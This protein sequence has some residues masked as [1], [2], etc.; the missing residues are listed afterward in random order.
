MAALAVIAA[1][2]PVRANPVTAKQAAE[3]V[4]GWL[5]YDAK[6]MG[7]TLSGQIGEVKGYKGPAGKLAYYVVSLAPEGFVIVP[8]D[9]L[10]E[11]IIAFSPRGK[12]EATRESPW[13]AIVS[14]D[15]PKRVAYVQTRQFMAA[16]ADRAKARG[17]LELASKRWSRLR[18]AA[19]ELHT[20]KAVPKAPPTSVSDVRVAPFVATRWSQGNS[21]GGHCYNYYTPN[22]YVCGCVATALAQVL[23]YFEVPQFGVGTAQFG[24]SVDMVGQTRNLRGGDGYGGPYD[25]GNMVNQ[26][27]GGLTDAQRRAIGALCHDAGVSVNMM[28]AAGGSG[29]G[30]SRTMWALKNVFGYSGGGSIWTGGVDEQPDIYQPIMNCNFDAGRPVIVSIA[31]TIEPGTVGHA[32]VG[33]GYGYQGVTQYH[34][35]NMGWGGGSDG[36]Y[37]MF[38]TWS[39]GG[40]A[41]DTFSGVGYNIYVTG[42]DEIVSGRVV[43]GIH[44]LYQPIHNID[45]TYTI[46]G[47]ATPAVIGQARTV[48]TNE[49]GIFYFEHVPSSSTL[50]VKV[51]KP[52]YVFDG[53]RW[54]WRPEKFTVNPLVAA[55]GQSGG[56]GSGNVWGLAYTGTL[57]YV[58][59]VPNPVVV[60]EG[61]T[62]TL[63]VRLSTEPNV[64]VTIDVQHT[65]GDADLH[66]T[67]GGSLS[68]DRTNWDSFQLVTI[69]A[70]EDG[71]TD[72]GY[73][74]IRCIGDAWQTMTV[75]AVEQ[76][77]DL[78]RILTD[79][80][81]LA[82]TEGESATFQVK[83]S[84]APPQAIVVNA[85]RA[86]SARINI[87][88]STAIAFTP[89]NWN[90]YQ[91]VTLTSTLDSGEMVN[92]QATINLTS[93]IWQS[94]SVAVTEHD[95]D[96]LEIVTDADNVTVPENS[97]AVFRVWLRN[98][99]AGPVNVAVAP[100]PSGD[101]DIRVLS[102]AVLVF[103]DTNWNV[104]QTVTLFADPDD[105]D[106]INGTGTITCA[107]SGGYP[108][109]HVFVTEA[110][111][112]QVFVT[113]LDTVDVPENG[114]A[115]L[116]A[117]LKGLPSGDVMVSVSRTIGDGD[118]SV[119]SGSNM[120]FT[121]LNWNI[122]QLVTLSAADDV[123]VANGEATILIQTV[124]SGWDKKHVL[125]R[126]VDDDKL[127]VTDMSVVTVGEGLTGSFQVR[128]GG[129]PASNVFVTVRRD[130]GDNDIRVTSSSVLTFGTGNWNTYQ[131]VDLRAEEDN[132]V[133]EG[134]A[135]LTC[136]AAGWQ[137]ATVLA[138]E[139]ENDASLTIAVTP[140]AGARTTTPTPGTHVYENGMVVSATAA[141]A[142][143][144]R[145][146]YWGGT[147]PEGWTRSF[148]GNGHDRATWLTRDSVGNIYVTG[149]F[150][151]TVDFD[152]SFVGTDVRSSNGNSDIFVT[153]LFSSGLYAWTRT[154]G[155]SSNDYPR[156]VAIDS[157]SD[158]IVTGEFS[159]TVDFDPG[160]GVENHSSAGG[161][162]AFV[163][164]LS[165]G[166]GSHVWT[167]TIGSTLT[168]AGMGVAV[169]ATD[170]LF[171]CGHFTGTVDL[172]PTSGTDS[173]VSYGGTDV[174][175][176]KLKSDGSYRWGGAMG[177]VLDDV[178]GKVAV[179]SSGD[180]LVVGSFQ[181]T[182]DFDPQS[183]LASDSSH[184]DYDIFVTKVH[185]DGT[186]GWVRTVGSSSED[187]GTAVAVDGAGAVFTTGYYSGTVDFDPTSGTD[188]RASQGNTD[189]FVAKLGT[190]GSYQW[191]R[192]IGG[193][194][195]DRGLSVAVDST[196]S[197]LVTGYFGGTA[198]FIDQAALPS[199][200]LH[201]SVG[202]RDVF[203]TRFQGSGG[204]R[205]SRTIGGTV[206]DEG[207]AVTTDADRNVLTVGR[208]EDTVDFDPTPDFYYRSSN[209][210]SDVFVTRL[211]PDGDYMS[212]TATS[213]ANPVTVMVDRAKTL[214][215][216]FE[217][218][219]KVIL[220]DVEAVTVAEGGSAS[221]LVKLR[222]VPM[223]SLTVTVVS[224]GDPDI[225]VSPASQNLVFNESNWLKYQ[226]V[227]LLAG[228]DDDVLN[229]VATITCSAAGWTTVAVV[230]TEDDDDWLLR[231][232]VDDAL[233]GTTVPA[234]GDHGY[235]D[236]QVISV[237]A[238]AASGYR[239][240]HWTGDIPEGWCRTFGGTG[241]DAAT[242]VA[243]SSSGE[244]YVC[245]Y[246]NG[247]V[248]FDPSLYGSDVRISQGGADIFVGKFD[249]NG[250][251]LWA[252][253]MGGP[254]D[255]VPWC[256]AVDAVGDVILTGEFRGTVDLDPTA[257]IDSRTSNGNG[258]VFVTKLTS[259]GGYV[260]TRTFGSA[261][262]DVGRGVAV[263]S[264][265]RIYVT[266]EFANTVAFD[267]T[268]SKMSQGG[269]DVFLTKL[270]S[271][272]T[273]VWTA[274]MGGTEDDV[275][276]GVA[277]DGAD[278]AYVVGQFRDWVDFDPTAADDV[279]P[280]NG[281]EDVFVTKL[282]GDGSYGWTRVAGGGG[283]DAATHVLID[284]NLSVVVCGGFNDVV[285]FDPA[286]GVDL[287]T[288][289]GNA[290][291]FVMKLT[292]GGLYQWAK[293]FGGDAGDMA[294]A[295]ALDVN[296][297]VHVAGYFGSSVDFDPSGATATFT[298]NGSSDAFYT[299][300]SSTG[301]YSLTRTV[302]SPSDDDATGI[303]VMD[304]GGVCLVGS[305][306][307]EVN[308]DPISGPYLRESIGDIDVF[309][310]RLNEDG[311]Y[312]SP[313]HT[314]T[315]NPLW[316]LMDRDKTVTAYFTTGTRLVVADRD[317]V[318]V[319]EGSSVLFQVKLA[320]RPDGP[321][322]VTVT[323]SGD[324]DITVEPSAATLTFTSSN[325]F[326][327]QPVTLHAAE[328]GDP[329]DGVATVTCAA[330][331]WRPATVL[332]T[333]ADDDVSLTVGVNTLT[334]G[335]TTPAPGIYG[336]EYGS[337]VSVT[338]AANL[339]YWFSHWSGDTPEGWCRSWGSTGSDEALGV[340]H[341]GQGNVYIC[342]Y[343]QGVVDLDPTAG[344][345]VHTSAGGT[346]AF[347]IKLTWDG[348]FS[349]ARSL[350]GPDDDVA[351]AVAV[352]SAGQVYITGQFRDTVDFDSE[353]GPDE[354]TS[355]GGADVFITAFSPAGGYVRAFTFGGTDDE[356]ARGVAV[357]SADAVYAAGS[358]RTSVDFDPSGSGDSRTS[359]GES[360]VF[361]TKHAADGSYGWTYSL[362]STDSDLATAVAISSAGGVYFAGR[363]QGTI[364]F[365][366]GP[367]GTDEHSATGGYDIF[368]TKLDSAAVYQWTRSIGDT[369]QDYVEGL[370]VDTSGNVLLAGYFF[371]TVDFD[372]TTG[373]DEHT[374]NGNSD[375]FVTKLSASGG[376]GWTRTFGGV[377]ND[378]SLGVTADSNENV[379]LV[380]YFGSIVDFDPSGPVDAHTA[381][382]GRDV[383]VTQFS[384]T[385]VYGWTRVAGGGLPDEA[386]SVNA[387]LGDT[388]CFAGSFEGTVNFDPI[389]RGYFKT[390]QGGA[391]GFVTRL[392]PNGWYAFSGTTSASAMNLVMDRAT[393]VQAN[394][395]KGT[396]LRIYSDGGGQVGVDGV[397]YGFP[398]AATFVRGVTTTVQALPLVGRTV[399]GGWSDAITGT[400]NPEVVTM[401]V[402]RTV[403][404]HFNTVLTT[405]VTPVAGG[406]IT[407]T[408]PGPVYPYGTQVTL[409]AGP[410]PFWA[411]HDWS[412]SISTTTNPV[413]I[414]MDEHKAV[415][416]TFYVLLNTNVFPS[417]SG[418]ITAQPEGPAYPLGSVV[419]LTAVENAG[420]TFASWSGDVS[421]YSTVVTLTMDSPKTV[422]AVFDALLT[423][424]VFPDGSG[425]ITADPVGPSYAYNTVVTLTA[426]ESTGW[427]FASW[428][429]H[430]SGT[431]PVVTI[432]MNAPKAVT[433]TFDAILTTYVYPPQGGTLTVQ[434]AGP[435]YPYNTVVTLTALPNTGWA[436]AS[437]SG[438]VSAASAVVTLTMDGPKAATATFD[439]I[440][441]IVVDPTQGGTIT[442]SPIGP[443]YAYNSVVT[444]TATSNAGWF[445]HVWSGA[446]TG[447]A[448]LTS[449]TMDAPKTVT[450]TFRPLLRRGVFPAGSGTI[451]TSPAGPAYEYGSVI[452][453]TAVPNSGWAFDFWS[454]DL[455]GT[456]AVTT[457]TMDG[458]K[459]VTATFRPILTRHVFPPGSG[460]ITADPVGPSYTYNSVVTVTAVPYDGWVF[461]SWSG[462][463]S[464]AGTVVT[465]TVDGPKAV[466][467]TF[468]A[469]LTLDVFPEGTGTI[470]ASPNLPAYPYNT[471]VTLT[472]VPVAGW[473]FDYWAGDA[474][475]T[476]SVVTVTMTSPKTVTA[477]FGPV[478][479]TD[480]F[481]AGSG[482]IS[483][484]PAGPAY[485]YME[486]VT[487]T[488]LPN[489]GWSF[490][491][492]SGAVTATSAVVTLTMDSPKTVTAYFDPY[493]SL[494]VDPHG[495]G[496][497]TA[498]P[499]GPV[500]PYDSVV[501][502]TSVANPG[503]SFHQWSGAAT[504]PFSTVQVH[505]DG[506]KVVTA[507]FWPLLAT[508]IDP[509]D[510]GWV[511]AI[512]TGP[513]YPMG[514]L[515]T[516]TANPNTGWTFASWSGDAVGTTP[517]A[518]VL[519]DAPKAVTATFG[520]LLTTHVSPTGS[521]SIDASPP[522]PSYPFG[523][524]VTLSATANPNWIF[525]S[526]SGDAAGT[527]TPVAVTME[528]PK[529]VT[530]NFVPLYM[531]SLTSP[532]GFGRIMVNGV[533]R[534]F[535][536]GEAFASGTVVQVEAVPDTG[537]GLT[538]WGGDLSG[539]ESPTTITMNGHKQVQAYFTELFFLHLA[540]EGTGEG[541]VQVYET[542][543]NLP[544][545]A[546]FPRTRVVTLTAVPADGS[547]FN[548]W[549]GD[550][551]SKA[552]PVTV[553]V[554]SE[555]WVAVNFRLNVPMVFMTDP[556]GLE[557]TI[558]GDVL[559]TPV[560]LN[561]VPGSV[562][563]VTAASP[564]LAGQRRHRFQNWSDGEGQT[565]QITAEPKPQK[566][567]AVFATEFQV[568]TEVNPAG[569]G[570]VRVTPVTDGWYEMGTKVRFTAL[571][572]TGNRFSYWDLNGKL[573]K[574][575]EQVLVMGKAPVHA[576]ANMHVEKPDYLVAG[577]L[578]P[579][580]ADINQSVQILYAISNQG[581][582]SGFQVFT[583][584]FASTDKVFSEDDVYLGN[585]SMTDPPPYSSKKAAA[586]LAAPSGVL[587][588]GTYLIFAKADYMPGGT[589]F[590]DESDETNNE[591][592]APFGTTFVV[593]SSNLTARVTRAPAF[594]VSGG[595]MPVGYAVG[596]DG[597]EP[598]AR[599]Y[600]R[601]VLSVNQ[602]IGDADDISLGTY[603]DGA[604]A[605]GCGV[606]CDRV[607]RVPSSTP[608]GAYYVGVS[609]DWYDYVHEVNGQ[610]APAEDDNVGLSADVVQIGLPVVDPLSVSVCCAS[611]VVCGHPLSV[612]GVIGNR[613]TGSVGMYVDYRLRPLGDGMEVW[614]G[615]RYVGPVAAGGQVESPAL[616][617]VPWKAACGAYEL[618]QE[619]DRLGQTDDSDRSNNVS[620]C[621]VEVL[622]AS[623]GGLDRPVLVSPIGEV[624]SGPLQFVWRGVGGAAS[625]EVWLCSGGGGITPLLVKR[626]V[627]GESLSSGVVVSDGE[628]E[629][630]V[631]AVGEDGESWSL[632]GWFRPVYV[633]AAG[634]ST[635]EAV[636][637]KGEVRA[638][639]LELR[640][641]S[642]AGAS[643]YE[644]WLWSAGESVCPRYRGATD[645]SLTV[646]LPGPVPTGTYQ[647]AVRAVSGG[648]G[649]EWCLPVQV[650]VK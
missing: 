477:H 38:A 603:F 375:V 518:T 271:D 23:K 513:A 9:D 344:I 575:E 256:M 367:V 401:D 296:D 398:Y 297:H 90:Q 619:V 521:G 288:A 332:A 458:P 219:E 87:T 412:G 278:R 370:A 624:L 155:G 27:G 185:G 571:P 195:S 379:V 324:T 437:W 197:V 529:D 441:T 404:V 411:F 91:T 47:S 94:A 145:F 86:G 508:H 300:L 607:V 162:D 109:K 406:A 536:Y 290:D 315:A 127:V 4:R 447:T 485:S 620:V 33:D 36:W 383:F 541:Q 301:A 497:I 352:D 147:V 445:F 587:S 321:L 390:S 366:T 160:T 248:D 239:F 151:G 640:W 294:A 306:S 364:D 361:L 479:V 7:E 644:V 511:G 75:S 287:H 191:T 359:A 438:D 583:S 591:L 242:W 420:W 130:S 153:K 164:K 156:C 236:S 146:S 618:V 560:T 442:A 634:L 137:T 190:S 449:F 328:D 526:W 417:G 238:V 92:D 525:S 249:A 186:H 499:P 18:D 491:T 545:S 96:A 350:G 507:T 572:L 302:G 157:N 22:N 26:P 37:N 56:G 131:Q 402:D 339:G 443:A 465:I 228:E 384:G 532:T 636:S 365:D 576:I 318:S 99:P 62:A 646:T 349:W 261:G 103:N 230:A 307:D 241:S 369:S 140:T 645:G 320:D 453:V 614:L 408:P 204:Y 473:A 356:D 522:G 343:F 80:D 10:V 183:G 15:V 504:G 98:E 46:T 519:M 303:V 608:A 599:V 480:V 74:V 29:A 314:A 152:P 515:V 217:I 95:V 373:T 166:D 540:G 482:T 451:T 415:T 329:D 206:D 566:Y 486:V 380:G 528:E 28:Y 414:T 32:I 2:A 631:R 129:E 105:A 45:V 588:P 244:T 55:T 374:S 154:I 341:D 506:P 457:L 139:D 413:V 431:T 178:A 531:L 60:E 237:S 293:T 520:V 389:G 189:A 134:V 481:P 180:V 558:D 633:S 41:W 142:V 112:D 243:K 202:G 382:G 610:G 362:G 78:P 325:W 170:N 430:A 439:P 218:S 209:G 215:A 292:N 58:E 272:N 627:S 524:L 542:V 649:G 63:Q 122:A 557:V 422:T 641:T 617:G 613:G 52:T 601:L 171:L 638:Q 283:F 158:L 119:T 39:A 425:T 503:W 635:P 527:I 231:V 184:G 250:L 187:R 376:H 567:C 424:D 268:E 322:T 323:R 252:R 13:H 226:T 116:T 578:P 489:T 194:Q 176:V 259:G 31:D 64:P 593:K 468:D 556:D 612:G 483:A 289:Q 286:G 277:V 396:I 639:P 227:T 150:Q 357:D 273:Y 346:D 493:L 555:K 85:S 574:G 492:W 347:V 446:A 135:T 220:T 351:R 565:H 358:F 298:A 488:A 141:A 592:V 509:L 281:V 436:F 577:M 175:I 50:T 487:L 387:G 257:G 207:A 642:V 319:P 597:Q 123:D 313:G 595:E 173:R 429:G 308:F 125:A 484:S 354:R 622:A 265:L 345:D 128:L 93:L 222:D 573:V 450:G 395:V 433:A 609:T 280:S 284:S 535:P 260:W 310:L 371:G 42:D 368:V 435:S 494:V 476:D 168:D 523:S 563:D 405:T 174:F 452:T 172:D 3:A 120:T 316:L 177:G 355:Y 77:N 181:D 214:T 12:Y 360:D 650:I 84:E 340:T 589:T 200:D 199:S 115:T 245:G 57:N 419:T 611:S 407:A 110:E 34:H 54:R 163:T 133:D 464:G 100:D 421:G 255:D 19:A 470:T 233:E 68:F 102:G 205:W 353:T 107:A 165:S 82:I 24:I 101:P 604:V 79:V 505:M 114:T 246:F 35:M 83:L 394:F 363:Y 235:E 5:R 569:S 418:T 71:D 274:A 331:G 253:T 76:D 117:R 377:A 211:T 179:D 564:Q 580:K 502:L 299:R 49:N 550:V 317:A 232:G 210:D 544:Y 132:D 108:D 596:Q 582:R 67:S 159:G 282:F 266:G 478:L 475:G 251:F 498:S 472:G 490:K 16:G 516:L 623:E 647:W 148:G 88:S 471:V 335:T 553:T 598:Q 392:M 291:V 590:V 423:L 225:S 201:T 434:P 338:Q 543:V 397:P 167:R 198:Q 14:Q 386:K 44:H 193:S 8:A 462:A 568:T 463:A 378:A 25:W 53:E 551:T 637:P 455:S 59:M 615:R 70:D 111:D 432:T 501:T 40:Y 276:R 97:T 136:T 500:Y 461:N 333:E 385:G 113:S 223:G 267:A 579:F 372:P 428:S 21:G 203:L 426:V 456:G 440:L 600:N 311:S 263:G 285:D 538:R 254:Q 213:T 625:Y 643:G 66:I 30:T 295:F 208:F 348:T 581:E 403:T 628:Y 495:S 269:T 212:G 258:D 454:G 548:G 474:G 43:D 530:G 586:I 89:T 247:A 11:P 448:T 533:V 229:S 72:D 6:P 17:N 161:I 559:T 188:V 460:T 510:S 192:I 605:G 61:G 309:L 409:T 81:E 416:G 602:V 512:P 342:G 594:G 629:W 561:W 626:G 467:A 304:D 144:Y 1:Q 466:T 621:R 196:N 149:Y 469:I 547:H 606:S 400:T 73:R 138:T 534:D 336:Y 391:D 65:A 224:S 234:P 305:F 584:F 632:P 216:H 182:A 539:F 330:V 585:H 334:A 427:T 517:T 546:A 444:L 126:E 552:N 337:T 562:H 124:S 69:A 169:D 537:M 143:G 279:L 630:W 121:T 648:A 221:F 388:I 270:R 459:A 393:A 240:S 275:G 549:S 410:T 399:F 326:V 554:S 104:A 262:N 264:T 118:I 496:T 616:L 312:T 106:A 514:T 327:F 381:V 20:E 51:S 48:K 570:H